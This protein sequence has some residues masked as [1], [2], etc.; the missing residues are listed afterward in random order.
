[1]KKNFYLIF[2]LVLAIGCYNDDNEIV[3]TENT[4]HNNSA[5]T[6]MLKSIAQHN[7]SFD[8]KVDNSSCFSLD[9]P[10]QL[11]VNSELRNISSVS[12]LANIEENDDID[13][14][15]PVS[16]NFYNYEVHQ[17]INQTEFN[18]VQNACNENF[19]ITPNYCLDIQFPITIKEFNDLTESFETYQLNNDKDVYLHFDNLHDNDVYEIEYPIFF[20]DTNS[21]SIRIDNNSDFEIAYSTSLQSCN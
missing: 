5:L 11:Y 7:A 10:Y 8:N 3:I 19:N 2:I 20:V 6:T 14:V 9:F 17:A 1:M 4:S 21:N 13:I 15:F 18:L 16:T 12:D